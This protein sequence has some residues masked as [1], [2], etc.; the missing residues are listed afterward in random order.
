VSERRPSPHS[1]EVRLAVRHPRNARG[2]RREYGCGGQ[3]RPKEVS[4]HC[5]FSVGFTA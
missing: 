5:F 1:G 4:R 2:L 3:E